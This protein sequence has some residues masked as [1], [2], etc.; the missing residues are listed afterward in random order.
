MLQH[1][2][3]LDI[4]SLTSAYDHGAVRCV[5]PFPDC[6]SRLPELCD[7]AV[8][9]QVPG[10]WG[11]VFNLLSIFDRREIDEWRDHWSMTS[12]I[13]LNDLAANLIEN[14]GQDIAQADLGKTL[15]GHR[16]FMASAI[17][18]HLRAVAM[19][20]VEKIVA[21]A[22]DALRQIADHQAVWYD[23]PV[24]AEAPDIGNAGLRDITLSAAPI[25]AGAAALTA[26][27]AMAVTT[28][29]AWFG[30][31]AVTTI[32]WPVV[33]GGGALAAIA[34]VAGGYRSGGILDRSRERLRKSVHHHVV[35]TLLDGEANQPSILQQLVE[36]FGET[37]RQAKR[38]RP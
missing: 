17:D 29:T 3:T 10:K 22:N 33:V 32:S 20:V 37:A 12:A 18:P 7:V 38:R 13:V 24:A 23:R 1:P 25:A 30:L 4:T 21:D 8:E 9:P 36:L 34:I 14:F 26:L 19:P 2:C 28:S 11:D 15:F 27:P 6:L 16:D 31:V 35:A 5:G